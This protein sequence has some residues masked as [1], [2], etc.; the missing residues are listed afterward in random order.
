M[1]HWVFFRPHN[2]FSCH[3]KSLIVL[4][5]Y[6]F[7]AIKSAVQIILLNWIDWHQVNWIQGKI[8]WLAQNKRIGWRY[9]VACIIIEEC[10]SLGRFW[11]VVEIM[12]F[13]DSRLFSF[14]IVLPT[15]T[16]ASSTLLRCNLLCL[17]GKVWYGLIP[18]FSSI[19]STWNHI[20]ISVCLVSL[21]AMV[22]Q[23]WQDRDGR[24]IRS[25]PMPARSLG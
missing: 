22:K 24:C 3:I 23:V 25:S 1:V 2:M 6:S 12:Y 11:L 21:D 14:F 18:F 15:F 19:S 16:Q 20:F 7:L 9:V 13:T 17:W 5:S 4:M 10:Y 8:N